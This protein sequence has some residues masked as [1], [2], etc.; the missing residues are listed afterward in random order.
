VVLVHGPGPT[1]GRKPSK[2]PDWPRRRR[3]WR[4]GVQRL[5]SPTTET[6]AAPGAQ[7]AN[8]VPSSP[9]RVAGCEPSF[10]YAR[11]WVLR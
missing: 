3:K 1:P 5:N 4:C 6:R 9:S 10:R 11:S 2:M 8:A 7:T